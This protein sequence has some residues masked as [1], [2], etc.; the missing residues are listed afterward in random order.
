MS[1]SVCASLLVVS[2]VHPLW[3]QRTVAADTRPGDVDPRVAQA[4]FSR[5][6]TVTLDHLTLRQAI[7]TIVASAGVSVVYHSDVLEAVTRRVSLRL[8]GVSL[9]SAL[10]QV[11]SGTTFIP[12]PLAT[13]KVA[14]VEPSGA[15]HGQAG[16]GILRGRVVDSTKG[17]PLARVVVSVVG[18]SLVTLTT[19]HGTYTLPHVPAGMQRVTM[20]LLGYAAVT[21]PVHVTDGDSTTLDVSLVATPT[22]LTEIVTTVTGAQR[23][24]EIPNDIARVNADS[25]MRTAPIL[26]TSD[27][28]AAAHVPGVLVTPS[29]GDPGAPSRIR[30]R[31]I[32][33]ISES[34]DPVIIVDGVWITSQ[35]STNVNVNQATNG[36]MPTRL[37]NLD[38]A[39]IETIEIVRGPSAATLYGPQAANGVIVITTKKGHAGQTHFALS[40][41]DNYTSLPSHVPNQYQGVGHPLASNTV[42]NCSVYEAGQQLCVQ[43]SVRITNPVDPFT[44]TEATGWARMFTASLDGGA[45]QFTYALTGTRS[46]NDGNR[47][48][49]DVDAARL[50]LLNID[51]PSNVTRPAQLGQ[52]SLTARADALPHPDLDIGLSYTTTVSDQVQSEAPALEQNWDVLRNNLRDTASVL[53][54]SGTVNG[55]LGSSSGNDNTFG[56]SANWTPRTW[57]TGRAN[58]GADRSSQ[59]NQSTYLSYAC[60][61]G[62]CSSASGSKTIARADQT[63]YSGSTNLNVRANQ[64]SRAS[65]SARRTVCRPWSPTSRTSTADS[66]RG[67]R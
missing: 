40:M 11:L 42:V 57:L 41:R 18:T 23:R 35:M 13:T 2:L 5:P 10:D 67:R 53:L 38:P 20:K 14:I 39:S 3:G 50:R 45:S 61:L 37:D 44:T 49:S 1:R 30:I 4:L 22:A 33:S 65:G 29:S 6:V 9:R 19:E 7:D 12:V 8:T 26:N 27:L 58:A 64:W 21:R 62:A 47:T 15:T 36:Y 55:V 56:V 59:D 34:N 28:I 54:A 25:L 66:W 60:V 17:T 52:T 48:I 63:V 31:G 24:V 46:T 43:D 51:M 16:E 32:G